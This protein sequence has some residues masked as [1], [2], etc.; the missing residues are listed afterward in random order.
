MYDTAKVHED[1]KEYLA[2]GLIEDPANLKDKRLYVYSGL[3]NLLFTPSELN[4]NSAIFLW[5]DL[6]LKKR[7]YL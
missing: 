3:R 2:M 1:I 6:F 5:V 4:L 7:S